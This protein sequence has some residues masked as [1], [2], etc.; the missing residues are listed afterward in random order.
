MV[1]SATSSLITV[2]FI[3]LYQSS[4]GKKLREIYYAMNF[5]C[6][7]KDEVVAAMN[8][9]N[10]VIS[11]QNNLVFPRQNNITDVSLNSMKTKQFDVLK[12]C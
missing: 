8:N 10:L 4:S 12:W 11:E 1:P 3:G 6:L 9:S 7:L 5:K 2:I